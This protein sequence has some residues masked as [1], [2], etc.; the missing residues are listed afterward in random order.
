MNTIHRPVSR[1]RLCFLKNIIERCTTCPF[2]PTGQL[3]P[4]PTRARVPLIRETG[5]EGDEYIL[6][7]SGDQQ[8]RVYAIGNEGS[9]GPVKPADAGAGSTRFPSRV[10]S[11][12]RLPRRSA[13][14]DD[15]DKSATEIDRERPSAMDVLCAAHCGE[16]QVPC[17]ARTVFGALKECGPKI[18]GF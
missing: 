15:D 3:S 6:T 8:V 17:L 1:H 9:G 2:A 4:P 13:D 11:D 10:F 7:F 5:Q 14:V 16:Q 18:M 12:K